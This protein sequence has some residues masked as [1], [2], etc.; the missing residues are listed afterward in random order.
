MAH[1]MIE[2]R[3]QFYAFLATQ[4]FCMWIAEKKKEIASGAHGHRGKTGTHKSPHPTN[5]NAE[6]ANALASMA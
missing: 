6:L 3:D 1:S 4:P 2:N 5:D